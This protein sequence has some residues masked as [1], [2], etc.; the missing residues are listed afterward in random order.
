[1]KSIDIDSCLVLS[2][3]TLVNA[4]LQIADKVSGYEGWTVDETNYCMDLGIKR[5]YTKP[6]PPTK[7]PI[8]SDGPRNY[9][10]KNSA[11]RRVQN[12]MMVNNPDLFPQ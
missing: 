12:L 7:I 2:D 5:T 8:R 1:M 3:E 6:F 9:K 4:L 11:I 10:S